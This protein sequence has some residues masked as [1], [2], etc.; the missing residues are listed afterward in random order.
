MPEL[1]EVETVVRGLDHLR[2]AVLSE[3]TLRRDGWRRPVPMARLLAHRGHPVTGLRRRGKWP[4]L[5]FADGC[6]WLHLGMTGQLRLFQAN[7]SVP[8]PDAHD[9]LDLQFADGRLLRFRDARRFGVVAWTDGAASE[10]PT[11]EPLGPEPLEPAWTPTVLAQALHGVK[12]PIKPTLMDASRVVGVGNIYA[13]EALFRAGVHPRRPAGSLDFPEVARVHA[14]VL[15]VL[16]EGIA[17][18][19]S[20]LQDHRRVNGESGG[21]Q[22]SHQVYARAGQPCPHCGTPIEK[23]EQAGRSTFFCPTCQPEVPP[24]RNARAARRRA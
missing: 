15:A 1:P 14:E 18:G 7:E 5:V 3:V 23:I 24:A 16:Q 9:H 6:L 17:A 8:A 10:P 13:S 11:R 4:A 2:G 20:T 21:Y 12:Q 22:D 19:G